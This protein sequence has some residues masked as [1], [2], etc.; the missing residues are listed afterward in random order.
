MPSV[1]TALPEEINRCRR[2]L[3]QCK[4]MRGTPGVNMEY[5]I[6]NLDGAI[7]RA[8]E[9]QGSGDVAAMLRALDDLLGF[10]S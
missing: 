10:K 1:A 8:I 4:E 3:D 9:A 7:T 5:M 2:L 6:A